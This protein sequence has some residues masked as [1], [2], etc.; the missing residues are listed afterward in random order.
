MTKNELV[1]LAKAK[2]ADHDLDPALLCALVETESAWY[3]FA[4]RTEKAFKKYYIDPIKSVRRYG[5][6]SYETE[7]EEAGDELRSLPS[8]GTGGARAGLCCRIAH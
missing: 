6:T 8:H 1:A 4:S 3:T 7:R 2:A 5:Q